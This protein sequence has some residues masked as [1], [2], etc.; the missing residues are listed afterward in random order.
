LE[1]F[2]RDSSSFFASSITVDE[3]LI[4][5][6]PLLFDYFVINTVKPRVVFA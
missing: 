2:K 1:G 6:S 3:P 4:S 5:S